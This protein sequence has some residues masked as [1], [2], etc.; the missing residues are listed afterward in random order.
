MMSP[1][2]NSGSRSSPVAA[3]T[4]CTEWSYAPNTTQV[5]PSRANTAGW[6]V[7]PLPHQVVVSPPTEEGPHIALSG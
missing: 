6:P 4:K 1:V 2:G 7:Q 5:R 3:S